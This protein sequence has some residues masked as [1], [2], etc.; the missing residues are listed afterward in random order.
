MLQLVAESH[1]YHPFTPEQRSALIQELA[2]FS[3]IEYREGYLDRAQRPGLAFQAKDGPGRWHTLLFQQDGR[4]LSY[5]LVDAEGT[6]LT[7]RLH[8]RNTHTD[9]IGTSCKK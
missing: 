5:E 4:L 8:L 6:V 7:H 9:S 3:D 1:L 2:R